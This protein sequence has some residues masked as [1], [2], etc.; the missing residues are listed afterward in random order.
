MKGGKAISKVIRDEKK[1]ISLWRLHFEMPTYKF[2]KAFGYSETV[3]SKTWELFLI[4]R[5]KERKVDFKYL[6][7]GFDVLESAIKN[8][9][10]KEELLDRDWETTPMFY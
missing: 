5:R 7:N 2:S 9:C 1:A 4:E 3:A 10:E 8:D 6:I